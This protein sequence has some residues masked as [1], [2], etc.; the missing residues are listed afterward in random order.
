MRNSFILQQE[1]RKRRTEH[2]SPPA[3]IPTIQCLLRWPLRQES[4]QE[5]FATFSHNTIGQSQAPRALFALWREASS[6]GFG[7]EIR[8]SVEKTQ[9]NQTK[10]TKQPINAS[11]QKS[12]PW[13]EPHCSFK[14]ERNRFGVSSQTGKPPQHQFLELMV[15]FRCSHY[16]TQ[17]IRQL[18]AAS[19][20]LLE[21]PLPSSEAMFHT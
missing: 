9:K 17:R 3:P 5:K 7:H 15:W 16:V 1:K 11:V 20:N 18:P 10:Q 21:H 4:F 6:M 19:Y 13:E 12:R 14:Q 8:C 2:S